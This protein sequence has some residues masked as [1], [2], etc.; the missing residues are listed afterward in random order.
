VQVREP[1]RA[2]KKSCTCKVETLP[3]APVRSKLTPYV[4]LAILSDSQ[5]C[6]DN[7]ERVP[8]AL[9]NSPAHPGKLAE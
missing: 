9:L 6:K 1:Y 7:E 2:K 5:D 3:R 8:V 4:L